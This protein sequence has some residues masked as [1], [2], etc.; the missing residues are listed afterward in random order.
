MLNPS[1]RGTQPLL[2]CNLAFALITACSGCHTITCVK[3]AVPASRLP[4]EYCAAAR[5]HC[6]PFPLT[7][8][9]QEKPAAHQ[10]GPGDQ[11]GVYVYGVLPPST[12]EAPVLPKSQPVN[13]RYYP[14][15]G[16]AVGAV[17]GLPMEVAADGTL[18][19]PLVGALDVSGM[20]VREATDAVRE[21][22]RKKEIFAQGG[23]E[24]VTVSLITPRVHR[25][26]VVREDTPSPQV[27]LLPPGQ[28][29]HI[30]RGSGEVIDLPIYE[31]DVLHALASTGGMPGTDA[32]R[33]I[34]VF[35]RSGLTNPH[36][37]LPE[38]LQVRTVSYHETVG[39]DRQVI[40]L[41]LAGC[42]GECVPY[43][44]SSVVL[45]EGDVVY[46]PRRAEY[47]YTGGLLGGAKL[48][49]PRDEDIDVL[50]AIALAN[51][52]TGGPLGQSGNALSAGS[53]GY[54]IRP[55]RVIIL[56]KM[57]DGRQLPIRV[58]LARAM[59]DEKERLLIQSDD[60]VMLQFKP[61]QAFLNGI[62]TWL[63]LNV[64]AVATG[65]N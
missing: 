23:T 10:I 13:Q 4:R 64:T 32:A 51:G 34:W 58:D 47:F 42:P 12:T 62:A 45:D 1:F 17:T 20:T 31:N 19:L 55:S 11:L 48:P 38:E 39:E 28:V 43:D 41:P 6:L 9:G 63:N 3:D 36:A 8:L 50:E 27:E 25:I 21:A 14:P 44:Q 60:V 52:S 30:H 24:R 59:T 7:A 49:L 61:H 26:L 5:E 29:D 56:R 40:R 16:S 2:I 57:H 33:E 35:K 37:I 46:V 18:D 53:P 65:R 15:N 54:L 22:Y